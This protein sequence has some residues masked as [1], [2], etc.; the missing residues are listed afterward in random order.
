MEK[1]NLQK[2]REFPEEFLYLLD[3]YQIASRV[4][5]E[6]PNLILEEEGDIFIFKVDD[7]QEELIPFFVVSAGPVDS[8][9]E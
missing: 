1:I 5:P 2:G 8:G 6:R 4:S 9:S 3:K 7:L